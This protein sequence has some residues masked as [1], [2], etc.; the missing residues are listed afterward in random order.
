MICTCKWFAFVAVARESALAKSGKPCAIAIHSFRGGQPG[1]LPLI[2][3][4]LI[5]LTGTVGSD[6]L[7]GKVGDK[8]GIFPGKKRGMERRREGGERKRERERER[9]STAYVLVI[10]RYSSCC[11]CEMH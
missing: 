9:E 11:F 6:W 2:K 8:A 10:L 5:E 4:E 3:G 7:R 1:D